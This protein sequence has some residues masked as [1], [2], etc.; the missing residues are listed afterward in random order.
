MV[1]RTNQQLG[2]DL[3]VYSPSKVCPCDVVERHHHHATQKASEKNRNPFGRIGSPDHNPLPF[4]D[5]SCL[6]LSGE[7]KR[8]AHHL[9]VGPAH[10]AIS[11]ALDVSDL[12]PVRKENW[13]VFEEG[14]AFHR[15]KSS[16]F[17]VLERARGGS[18]E[19]GESFPQGSAVEIDCLESVKFSHSRIETGGVVCFDRRR[20]GN[21][22]AISEIL[23]KKRRIVTRVDITFET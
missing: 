1:L 11:L 2:A 9:P 5:P 10:T 4:R 14:M 20:F 13:Q 16:A 3:A 15:E 18:R 7:A 22:A 19:T 6:E 23:R 17:H 12:L 21:R 8:H